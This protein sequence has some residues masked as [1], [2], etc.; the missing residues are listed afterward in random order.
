MKNCKKVIL[1]FSLVIVI[2]LS[3]SI[4]VFAATASVTCNTIT[5]IDGI[6]YYSPTYTSYFLYST[7]SDYRICYSAGAFIFKYNAGA[8][9]PCDANGKY[10]ASRYFVFSS[11]DEA[12][13]FLIDYDPE[14]YGTERT[15]YY[16]QNSTGV[17]CDYNNIIY[18]NV[19]VYSSTTPSDST[20]LKDVNGAEPSLDLEDEEDQRS[21]WDK[22]VDFFTWSDKDYNT[23]LVDIQDVYTSHEL[24]DS[25]I[26]FASRLN[27]FFGPILEGGQI[28]DFVPAIRI[29]LSK[30]TS[31]YL[32]RDIE[33]S[34]EWYKPYRQTVKD[35]FSAFMWGIFL[36]RLF[37][38][39][40]SVVR[41]E[42]SF[43]YGGLNVHRSEIERNSHTLKKESKKE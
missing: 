40:V 30:S 27:G 23:F 7:D 19:A 9:I 18:N 11:L 1:I 36:W 29:P 20:L 41:G 31:F 34:F 43:I 4:S 5:V 2:F 35:I 16:T 32:G 38:N 12:L 33:I 14:V 10:L 17:T 26:R 24:I 13:S 6:T 39:I 8:V 15:A 28:M 42:S 37:L 25:L 21:L 3:F 22:I